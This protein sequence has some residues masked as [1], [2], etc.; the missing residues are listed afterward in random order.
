MNLYI[1]FL[2]GAAY[3]ILDVIIVNGRNAIIQISFASLWILNKI[4]Q[5][6]VV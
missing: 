3:L 4:T 5:L 6:A 2:G 1:E